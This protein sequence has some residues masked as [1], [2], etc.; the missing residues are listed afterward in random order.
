MN[1]KDKLI[2]LIN[3]IDNEEILQYFYT[4]IVTKIKGEHL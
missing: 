3:S 2:N 1:Y 4:F